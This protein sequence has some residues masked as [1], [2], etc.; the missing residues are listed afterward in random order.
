MLGHRKSTPPCFLGTCLSP[1]QGSRLNPLQGTP[2]PQLQVL[3]AAPDGPSSCL[4]RLPL[5]LS[6]PVRAPA[7]G[8][9]ANKEHRGDL[10]HGSGLGQQSKS[11]PGLMATALPSSLCPS[12][13][14]ILPLPTLFLNRVPSLCSLLSRGTMDDWSGFRRETARGSGGQRTKVKMSAAG[15]FRSLCGGPCHVSL[16]SG[17]ATNPWLVDAPLWSEAAPCTLPTIPTPSWREASADPVIQTLLAPD[18]TP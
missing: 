13:S 12:T 3:A 11:R 2:P 15:S 6:L 16:A 4:S 14:M 10:K 7:R 17:A 1:W 18:S 8:Q 9:G 5:W